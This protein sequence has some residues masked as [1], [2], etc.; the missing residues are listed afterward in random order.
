MNNSDATEFDII[1]QVN[2]LKKREG[3]VV[4][5]AEILGGRDE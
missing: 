5:T 4:V 3:L 1:S 2:Q